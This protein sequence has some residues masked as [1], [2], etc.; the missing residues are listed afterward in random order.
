MKI[1]PSKP[2]QNY[3]PPVLLVI[4]VNGRQISTVDNIAL[5]DNGS[6][7]EQIE[8]SFPTTEDNQRVDILLEK[9]GSSFPYRGLHLLANVSSEGKDVP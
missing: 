4:L 8:F 9:Q 6:R 3:L 5:E 2:L 1:S 7:E